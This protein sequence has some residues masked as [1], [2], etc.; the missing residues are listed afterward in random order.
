MG[1]G[2]NARA[3]RV[4]RPAEDEVREHEIDRRPFPGDVT[5]W[6]VQVYIPPLI[7]DTVSELPIA[8]RV[9]EEAARCEG[10]GGAEKEWALTAFPEE[11]STKGSLGLC[12][13]REG[14]REEIADPWG[15]K[16]FT[17]WGLP[18]G[19]REERTGPWRPG[20]STH[21]VAWFNRR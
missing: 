15:K 19:M 9:R 8:E 5:W 1:R 16:A 3:A 21:L 4:L 14:Q 18:A 12:A 2:D 20:C 7:T 11:A 10:Y 17:A 13:W 6:S